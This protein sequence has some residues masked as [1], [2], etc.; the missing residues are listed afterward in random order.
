MIM[1]FLFVFQN[2]SGPVSWI[3][4]TETSNDAGLGVCLFSLWSSVF[5]M[6]LFGPILMGNNS[7]GASNVFFL[8]SGISFV[9][10]IF[11]HCVIKETQGLTD[12]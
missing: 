6:A 1:A 7:I 2:T 5:L 4:A 11:T 9:A 10:T 12:V 8:L 3:Y